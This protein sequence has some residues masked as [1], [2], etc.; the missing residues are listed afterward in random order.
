MDT[1]SCVPVMPPVDD[2][3][4]LTTPHSIPDEYNRLRGKD[5]LNP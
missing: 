4:M 1:F 2:A 3:Y 5:R